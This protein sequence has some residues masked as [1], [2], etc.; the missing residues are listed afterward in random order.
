MV[1]LLESDTRNKVLKNIKLFEKLE[2]FFAMF[3]AF[4][5]SAE[6]S[7]FNLWTLITLVISSSGMIRIH[8]NKTQ[9][10][11]N[12]NQTC[13]NCKLEKGDIQRRFL[14][15]K[16]KTILGELSSDQKKEEVLKCMHCMLHNYISDKRISSLRLF[17]AKL[18]GVHIEI[19]FPV[20]EV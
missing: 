15:G 19:D 8:N 14:C 4:Y 10:V 5:T 17:D 6:N 1:K 2:D 16:S 3:E 20:T 7:R 12:L 9:L 11:F 18:Q 13:F